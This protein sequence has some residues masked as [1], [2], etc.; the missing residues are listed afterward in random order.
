M[1][2]TA[3]APTRSQTGLGTLGWIWQAVTGAALIF[4][5]ALHMV[6]QHFVVEGG[7]RDYQ[8]VQE[9]LRNPI[10]L[11]LEVLFLISVTSH[12]L[13]GVRA[14]LFDFGLKPTTEK[15]ISQALTVFGLVAV[16]YGIWLTWVV[17]R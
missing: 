12:A 11:A 7:L 3:T 16:A 4:L 8:D 6:A 9:Y 1:Q 10:I 5:S 14:I 17:I 15:R 2:T 13:L